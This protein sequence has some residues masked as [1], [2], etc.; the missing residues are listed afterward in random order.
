MILGIG[1]KPFAPK[2]LFTI[3]VD[4][5]QQPTMKIHLLNSW[6]KDDMERNFYYDVDEEILK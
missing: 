4:E 1:G 5:A 2:L 6:K 3:P